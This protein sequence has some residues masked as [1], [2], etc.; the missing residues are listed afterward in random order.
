M[1]QTSKTTR[2]LTHTRA[3][4]EKKKRRRRRKN[5][6]KGDHLDKGLSPL[7]SFLLWIHKC[8]V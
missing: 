4:A 7:L 8:T 1:M 3:L 5:K 6:K 2:M